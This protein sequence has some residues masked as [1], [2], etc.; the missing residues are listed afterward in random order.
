MVYENVVALAKKNNL[1]LSEV[2]RK[3]GLAMAIISK[4]K[5]VSPNLGSLKAVADVFGVTVNR[6]IREEK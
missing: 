5:T 2:E 1:T 3:A 6:L 4:W